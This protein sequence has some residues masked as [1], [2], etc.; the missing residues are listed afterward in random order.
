MYN[1]FSQGLDY[2]TPLL[3][4]TQVSLRLIFDNHG[5]VAD[6][7]TSVMTE[8][9]PAILDNGPSHTDLQE[10]LSLRRE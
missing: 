10:K 2:C 1:L 8:R 9:Q 6:S 7:S 3:S 4:Q 5:L